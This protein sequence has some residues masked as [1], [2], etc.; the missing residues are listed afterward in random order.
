MLAK[1]NAIFTSLH[2]W[3]CWQPDDTPHLHD[4][5]R[6]LKDG[7]LVVRK[8]NDKQDCDVYVGIYYISH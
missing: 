5:G 8:G 7:D 6:L 3:H 1:F 2:V 4:Y